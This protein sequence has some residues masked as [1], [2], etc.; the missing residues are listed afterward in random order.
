LWSFL[1]VDI[2][3]ELIVAG[4]GQKNSEPGS[5]REEDL[6][7]SVNPHLST[8]HEALLQRHV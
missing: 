4:K 7:R 8:K 1:P 2:V 6:R 3:V 5:K